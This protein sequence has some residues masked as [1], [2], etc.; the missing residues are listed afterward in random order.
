MKMI[1]WWKKV[2]LLPAW[3]HSISHLLSGGVTSILCGFSLP[4]QHVHHAVQTA[5]DMDSSNWQELLICQYQHA[6]CERE[7][8]VRIF[9]PSGTVYAYIWHMS[10]GTLTFW[11]LLLVTARWWRSCRV[12]WHR[13]AAVRYGLEQFYTHAHDPTPPNLGNHL[14]TVQGC[15]L[16]PRAYSYKKQTQL[17]QIY[18]NR[19]FKRDWILLYFIWTETIYYFYMHFLPAYLCTVPLT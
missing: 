11:P 8:C 15:S 19:F 4:Q 18:F 5:R 13:R 10:A 14:K 6:C 3:I 7:K 16:S 17:M 9:I 12:V 2:K 1:R